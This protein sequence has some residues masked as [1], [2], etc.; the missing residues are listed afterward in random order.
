MNFM[1]YVFPRLVV[2]HNNVIR[3]NQRKNPDAPLTRCLECLSSKL[4]QIIA[5][6]FFALTTDVD[7]RQKQLVLL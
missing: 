1:I 5:L 6:Y 3:I 2:F 7:S 4:E